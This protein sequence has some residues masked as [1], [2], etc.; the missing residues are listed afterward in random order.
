MN[1]PTNTG[2]PIG[3]NALAKTVRL[4]KRLNERI[5]DPDVEGMEIIGICIEPDGQCQIK[6]NLLT[7]IEFRDV[8]EMLRYL[9]S[10]ISVQFRNIRF[11]L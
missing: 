9:E 7:L 1:K 3:E 5:A 11:S 8:D 10:S 2:K 4:L 6:S